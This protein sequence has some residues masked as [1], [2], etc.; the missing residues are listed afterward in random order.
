MSESLTEPTP[1][2]AQLAPTT[3]DPL[4][5]VEPPSARFIVQL[6][7]VPGLIVAAIIG[8]W[9]SFGQLARGEQDWQK[10]VQDLKSSNDHRRGRAAY[11]LAMALA[12]EQRHPPEGP[13]LATNPQVAQELTAFLAESLKNS[14]QEPTVIEQQKYLIGA[15]GLLDLPDVVFPVLR[16]ALQSQQDAEVR[17]FAVRSVATIAFR[18]AERGEA[19]SGSNILDDLTAASRDADVLLRG[20]TAFAFGFFSLDSVKQPLSVLLTDSDTTVR[21]NAAIAFTRH[22]SLDGLPVLREVL[23]SAAETTTA[24]PPGDASLVAATNVLKAISELSPLLDQ[25]T[26]DAILRDVKTISEQH[27]E[28]RVKLDAIQALNKMT[29]SLSSTQK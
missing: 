20:T 29:Q 26:R 16:T 7:V 11:G 22:K 24:S 4:P 27:P 1:D 23:K 10:L 6:F 19:I 5:P 13:R 15:V 9:W 8:V 17:R 14:S 18:A 3:P 21:T 2:N 25:E 28:A 12:A